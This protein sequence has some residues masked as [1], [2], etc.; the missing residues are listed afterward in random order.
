MH[1]AIQQYIH[2]CA[3]TDKRNTRDLQL[4]SPSNDVQYPVSLSSSPAGLR[5]TDSNEPS[6]ESLQGAS[7]H[8]KTGARAPTRTHAVSL[9]Q[10]R[11]GMLRLQPL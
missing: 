10:P 5:Q 1:T 2:K 8:T 4:S 3:H 6:T 7:T 9:D 11:G